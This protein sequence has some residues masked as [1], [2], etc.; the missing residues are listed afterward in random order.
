M[1]DTAWVSSGHGRL[2]AASTGGDAVDLVTGRFSPG[3]VLVAVTPGDP[4]GAPATCPGPGF[5][6]SY[7]GVLHPWTGH[8][9]RVPVHGAA[10][11]PQGLLFQGTPGG[12]GQER[13][14]VSRGHCAR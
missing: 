1:D 5:P 6:A 4:N 14:R 9:S 10:L 13:P 12:N 8:I 3:S 7:L 2:Y 11:Q